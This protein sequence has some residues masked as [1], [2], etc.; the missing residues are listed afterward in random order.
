MHS[1]FI[2]KHA[3]LYQYIFRDKAVIQST[4]TRLNHATLFGLFQTIIRPNLFHSINKNV[5]YS[6][7]FTAFSPEL[8]IKTLPA[9]R[10]VTGIVFVDNSGRDKAW[11]R[12]GIIL[13]LLPGWMVG[14][15][16]HVLCVAVLSRGIS[17]SVTQRE[18][19][20]FRLLRYFLTGPACLVHICYFF[21]RR[22]VTHT[23]MT[24]IMNIAKL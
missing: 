12:L 3:S 23:H 21:W 1:M 22:H 20:T 18:G 13:K 4:A 6:R 11:W 24:V 17:W 7:V 19:N 2:N 5:T 10:H 9:P 8:S 14:K 16:S 15:N